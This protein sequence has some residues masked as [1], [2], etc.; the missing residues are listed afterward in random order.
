MKIEHTPGPWQMLFGAEDSR[1]QI[2]IV[3]DHDTEPGE[4]LW[5][6]ASITNHCGE[7]VATEANARLVSAAP[8][9]LAACQLALPVLAAAAQLVSISGNPEAL[10]AIK[11]AVAKAQGETP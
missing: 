1:G 4:E 2:L 8:D 10:R 9:L 6:V 3:S 11:T 5:R 7:P